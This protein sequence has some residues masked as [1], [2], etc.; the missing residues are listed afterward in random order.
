MEIS[1]G[2]ALCSYLYKKKKTRKMPCLSFCL[3]S[4]AKSEIRRAEQ[5]LPRGEVWKQWETGSGRERG[6]GE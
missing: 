5:V 6:V 3:F 2:N 1:R 4:S